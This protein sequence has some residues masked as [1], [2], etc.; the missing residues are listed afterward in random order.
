MD[1]QQLLEAAD[2]VHKY[3]IQKDITIDTEKHS[4]LSVI[5]LAEEVGELNEQ[6]LLHYGHS[7]KEKMEKYSPQ[8]LAEE[9]ADV[10]FT[11]MLVAKSLD[12]DIQKAL[13]NKMEKI[14]TRL[15]IQ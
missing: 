2:K 9:I 12:V 3:F 11:T 8:N 10:I 6:I 14:Y 13:S 5:K 1:M 15:G 4:L 7:R